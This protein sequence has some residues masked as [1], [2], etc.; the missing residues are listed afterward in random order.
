[1]EIMKPPEEPFPYGKT[2]TRSASMYGRTRVAT[3]SQGRL[4]FFEAGLEEALAEALHS[5]RLTITDVLPNAMAKAAFVFSCVGTPSSASG[6]MDNT[7]LRRATR[8]L[9]ATLPDDTSTLCRG[10]E[11]RRPRHTTEAVVKPILEASGK[12]FHLAVTPGVPPGGA[13]PGGH[14]PP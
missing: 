11:H 8:D 6:S 1:M 14:P 10:E 5:G 2:R 3:I 4:P 13:R 12:P 7:F 9:A